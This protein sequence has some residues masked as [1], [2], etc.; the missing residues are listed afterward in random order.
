[1]YFIPEYETPN[2]PDTLQCLTLDPGLENALISRVKRTQHDVGLM[3]DP[4]I[5]EALLN[6]MTPKINRMI[7]SA[8]TP[9]VITT[10]ELRLALRRFL[11]PSFP[12]LVVLSYQ[13]MPNRMQIRPFDVLN[14]P[15]EHLAPSMQ[16]Q[17]AG[18][19]VA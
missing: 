16:Q 6:D 12:R 8:L 9:I 14:I 4:Q 1:M 13:E 10:V 17:G 7:E 15:A 19:E 2:E 11:E 18:N 3:M 5:T